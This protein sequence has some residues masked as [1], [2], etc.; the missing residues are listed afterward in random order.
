MTPEADLTP[1][2]VLH[3]KPSERLFMTGPVDANLIADHKRRQ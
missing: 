3:L 1:S 2:G